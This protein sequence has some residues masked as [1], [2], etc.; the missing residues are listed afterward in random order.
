MLGLSCKCQAIVIT[1]FSMWLAIYD[2]DAVWK[3]VYQ[4]YFI[5]THT[6]VKPALCVRIESYRIVMLKVKY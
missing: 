2:V 5:E 1:Q 3:S 6:F 4:N